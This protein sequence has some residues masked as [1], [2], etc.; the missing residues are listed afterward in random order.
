MTGLFG[1]RLGEGDSEA[2]ARHTHGG[3][4]IETVELELG[5][6]LA[7][8]LPR[9]AA[10]LTGTAPIRPVA[11]T[12]SP[13]KGRETPGIPDIPGRFATP[14]F[15][16]DVPAD[17]AVVIGTSGSTGTPKL[18][19]LSARALAAS[20]GA[21]HRHLG[22]PG[23]WLL[24]L[25]PHH[26]AGLQVLLRG[27]VA[28][29]STVLAPGPFSSH[30]FA[31]ATPLLDPEQRRYTALVP[32]QVARLLT[33]PGGRAALRDFD[34]VL[35]GG[36]ALPPRLRA[37]ADREG[38]IL[39]ATYG[40]SETA[41][42][43]VYDGMPL[44]DNRI[45]LTDEGQIELG[46]PTIADGYLGDPD[47]SAQ[48]FS[49][50]LDGVRWFRT[51]DVGRMRPDGRLEVLGRLDDLI[52]T[53][54]VKVAPRTVEEAILTHCPEV[55]EVVVVGVPDP[56]WGQR[57]GTLLVLASNSTALPLPTHPDALRSA[58]RDR[59]RGILPA[60]ALPQ[61]VVT[62]EAIPLRG[63]GKPDRA[64]ITERLDS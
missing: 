16:G 21:T 4:T 2:S 38:I 37:A 32:T 3:A 18:A 30:A 12:T 10:A 26:I 62:A 31:S 23:Q 14:R 13:S 6:D 28:G 33:D 42:G 22:G 58:L 34:A 40:M 59:L 5:P 48:A 56:D 63:P 57:V 60:H 41:G 9:L 27:L 54:G 15:L 36:A 1:N 47:R 53:G 8:K 39:V 17:L 61:Q 24:A 51:D 44:G 49:R 46:G 11:P 50:D 64:Q 45:R 43:C 7:A 19:M 20:I 25:P 55:S 35:V 29:T 52:N